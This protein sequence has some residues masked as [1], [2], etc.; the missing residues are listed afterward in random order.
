LGNFLLWNWSDLFIFRCNWLIYITDIGQEF[1]FNLIFAA[2][3]K[4]GWHFPPITRVDHMPFGLVLAES[5]K[6]I[7]SRE[8]FTQKLVN[9]TSG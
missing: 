5:G 7:K 6:K 4:I 3:K 2:A 8:G 1:H 9:L